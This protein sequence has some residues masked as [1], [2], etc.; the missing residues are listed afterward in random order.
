ME[1][2]QKD[3][4]AG[5]TIARDKVASALTFPLDFFMVLPT[6]IVR[7]ERRTSACRG[8]KYEALSI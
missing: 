1:L 3:R 4:E 2:S 8:V 7:L 6:K 5:I